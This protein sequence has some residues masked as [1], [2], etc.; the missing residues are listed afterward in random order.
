MGLV[1]AKVTLKNPRKPDLQRVEV[2]ALADSAAVH[3]YIP[4]HVQ[5]Q[6]G[7]DE[8]AKKEVTLADGG[9]KLVPYVGPVELHFKN[10]VGFAGALVLGDTVLLGAI[11]MEDMDLVII[12]KTRTLDVNPGSPNVATSVVK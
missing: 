6:L 10:R 12:P 3:L 9:K 5:I 8:I 2:D 4:A 11:P 1:N 7:L